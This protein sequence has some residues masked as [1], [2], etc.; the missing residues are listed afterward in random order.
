MNPSPD[1]IEKQMWGRLVTRR[2]STRHVYL[3]RRLG[4]S[5]HSRSSWS[6]RRRTWDP[7]VKWLSGRLRVF[8]VDTVPDAA[9]THPPPLQNDHSVVLRYDR[10]IVAVA[11][12]WCEL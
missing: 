1:R 4:I 5:C 11:A 9:E 10:W 3:H 8:C 7:V 2:S 6:D 12:V